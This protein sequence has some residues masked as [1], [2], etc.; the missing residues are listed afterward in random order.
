MSTLGSFS[1]CS[2]HLKH[3]A[4]PTQNNMAE[5]SNTG[6]RGRKAS[7]KPLN[8]HWVSVYCYRCYNKL[9]QT[10]R[11][12]TK[13]ISFLTV[14]EVRSPKSV[15][16]GLKSRSQQSCAPSRGSRENLFPCFFQFSEDVHIPSVL[17]PFFKAISVTSLW[18]FCCHIS[19]TSPC[20]P[21]FLPRRRTI[22]AISHIAL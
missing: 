19:V 22:L 12:K 2:H 21:R 16:P 14:M 17:A 8:K 11:L 9:S 18:L 4:P 1:Y 5:T 15:S 3:P 6:L 20:I 13:R 7:F 10:W